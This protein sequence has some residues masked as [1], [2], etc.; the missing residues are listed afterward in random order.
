MAEI[1]PMSKL[2][3]EAIFKEGLIGILETYK[4]V[5]DKGIWQFYDEVQQEKDLCKVNNMGSFITED[6]LG[7][8]NFIGKDEI[9][10]DSQIGSIGG[11]NHFVEIQK[12]TRACLKTISCI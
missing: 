3:R 6:I 9:S 4:N 8:E 1:F 11:G 10:Y 12:I 5:K 2:N 7:L